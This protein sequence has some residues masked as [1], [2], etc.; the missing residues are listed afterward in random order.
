MITD[1]FLEALGAWQN[2]WD[3]DQIRKK[4]IGVKLLAAAATLSARF[5]TAAGQTCYRKRFIHEGELTAV[6]ADDQRDEGIGSWTF[7]LAL[8]RKIRG[9]IS[10][11]EGAVTATIFKREPLDMEVVVNVPALWKDDEFIAAAESYRARGGANAD[12]LFNFLGK[13]DQNEIILTAPLQGSEILALVGTAKTFDEYCD[14]IGLPQDDR[15]D[16]LFRLATKEG[17]TFGDVRYI[18]DGQ[19]ARVSASVALTG[20]IAQALNDALTNSEMPAK[21]S[22]ET[23][24]NGTDD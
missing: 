14:W 24:A 11:D 4:P 1:D 5:K 18:S 12:A 17:M 8:A 10:E 3:T 2:G 16:E 23:H 9:L 21:T 19:A 6:F 13:N 7:D 22:K 20:Q 15:R